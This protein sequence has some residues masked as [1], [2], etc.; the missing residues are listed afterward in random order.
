MDTDKKTERSAGTLFFRG[1]GQL[2]FCFFFVFMHSYEA[3][4][5]GFFFVFFFLVLV[6]CSVY[7]G[8]PVACRSVGTVQRF[9][10]VPT[11]LALMTYASPLLSGI[12]TRAPT[13]LRRSYH[14]KWSGMDAPSGP[15]RTPKT[16]VRSLSPWNPMPFFLR[17]PSSYRFPSATRPANF[18][19]KPPTRARSRDVPRPPEVHD[20]ALAV[21]VVRLLRV[22]GEDEVRARDLEHAPAPR[23]VYPVPRERQRLR[24]RRRE[25]RDEALDDEHG[26]LREP[27]GHLRPVQPHERARSPSRCSAWVLARSRSATEKPPAAPASPDP[28][29]RPP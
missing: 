9:Q 21:L 4:S 14:W 6:F 18:G 29:R 16:R 5:G 3:A 17:P 24:E 12:V 11:A 13:G 26:G 2:F 20:G 7:L 15:S 27:V 22:V 19:P 1:C 25:V 10:S 23:V 28:R 8:A